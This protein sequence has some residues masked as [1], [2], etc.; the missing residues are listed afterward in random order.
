MLTGCL[1]ST[2]E[3]EVQASFMKGSQEMLSSQLRRMYDTEF[4]ESLASSRLAMSSADR[5]VSS[6]HPRKLS[7]FGGWPLPTGPALALQTSFFEG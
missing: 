4:S 5:L 1:N 2:A 3:K 7:P 6:C